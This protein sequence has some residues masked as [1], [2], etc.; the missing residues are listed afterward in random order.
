M[1]AGAKTVVGTRAEVAEASALQFAQEFYRRLLDDE[2]AGVAIRGARVALTAQPDPAWASFLLYGD[3]AANLIGDEQSAAVPAGV[4]PHEAGTRRD[5]FTPEVEVVLA[6]AYE[7][8]KARG[9]VTS[10]DLLLA[11]VTTEE[12]Q[13]TMVDAVGARRLTALTRLLDSLLGDLPRDTGRT[14]VGEDPQRDPDERVEIS[15]TVAKVIA[16]AE[17]NA[18]ADGRTVAT[19]K[20]VAA[21]FAEVGGGSSA[22]LLDLSGIS[23]QRLM[24]GDT[25]PE[26]PALESA[27]GVSAAPRNAGLFGELFNGDSRIRANRLDRGAA[28]GIR[29]ARL[30]AKASGK[31]IGS[32][33]L[34][35]GFALAGSRPL[36]HALARQSDAGQRAMHSLAGKLEPRRTDFSSRTLAALEKASKAETGA[37]L[38]EAEILVALLSDQ[39]STARALLR[40]LGVDPDVVIRDLRRPG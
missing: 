14:G 18:S 20:D 3:P 5:R 4:L 40:Q 34:L 15:D 31:S 32:Y 7:I 27:D 28:H 29:A 19:V 13:P 23:L 36:R 9:V 11:L 16:R 2:P 25:D 38:G 22:G 17:D 8:G 33:L 39:D 26:S 12:L 10:M 1:V 30:L 6:R 37:V 21:A 35:Q 24:L